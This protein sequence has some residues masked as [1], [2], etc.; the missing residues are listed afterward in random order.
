MS[1]SVVKRLSLA[2][3]I[4]ALKK[5]VIPKRRVFRREESALLRP[6]QRCRLAADFLPSVAMTGMRN[7]FKCHNES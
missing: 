3:E 2:R 6:S 7:Y 4:P 1:I 5:F